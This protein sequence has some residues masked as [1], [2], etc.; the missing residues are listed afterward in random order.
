MSGVYPTE[1]MV[2]NSRSSKQSEEFPVQSAVLLDTP[3]VTIA[4]IVLIHIL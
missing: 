4:K 3:K 1:D 2:E